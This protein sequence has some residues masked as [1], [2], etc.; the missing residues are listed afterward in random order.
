MADRRAGAADCS[1]ITGPTPK[2]MRA[3]PH[4]QAQNTK[5][6]LNVRFIQTKVT[7]GDSS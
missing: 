2:A 7:Y 5:P 3:F 6:D 1:W 4:N